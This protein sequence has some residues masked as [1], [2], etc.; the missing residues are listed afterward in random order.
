MGVPEVTGVDF[1]GPGSA[2]LVVLGP[3]LG[4]SAATLWGSV[5]QLLVRNFRVIGW[6]LPGHGGAPSA[7]QQ[8]SVAD[9]A[10]GVLSCVD[11]LATTTVFHYAGT[12]IGGCVGL[13]LALDAQ[14]RVRTATLL[15]TGASVGA[16]ADWRERADMVRR[17]GTAA[18]YAASAERWFAPGFTSR[19][20]EVSSRL[21][22]ALLDTDD[23]AYARVC[24]AFATFDFTACL[25]RISTPVLCIAGAHDRATP[26]E[27]LQRLALGV[28]RGR[29]EV[30]PA[31]GHLA[32]AE[33]PARVADLIT[34]TADA[35]PG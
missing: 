13:Q 1:G 10:C 25:S 20:P 19:E 30:L 27:T 8:F 18:M 31:A 4:T 12:S 6:N 17:A 16:P 11:R 28:Q 22:Q 29:L 3:S 7:A 2:P 34:R 26:P 9:L 33:D 5:A 35:Y 14:P 32:A 24:E 23:D 21:L 15:A